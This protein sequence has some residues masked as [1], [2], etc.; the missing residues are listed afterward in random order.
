MANRA[1]KYYPLYQHQGFHQNMSSSKITQ[2]PG[3]KGNPVQKEQTYQ[4]S[5]LLV[6]GIAPDRRGMGDGRILWNFILWVPHMVP[7]FFPQQR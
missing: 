3:P 1:R 7:S 2:I 5:K 4:R 6:L